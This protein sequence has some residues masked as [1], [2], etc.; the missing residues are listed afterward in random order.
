MASFRPFVT[1]Y[2]AVSD[3]WDDQL[4]V[5]TT[6]FERQI[7]RFLARGYR[8][9]SAAEVVESPHDA[10]LLHV[11]FDDAFASIA[12]TLSL[13]SERGVPSTV[14]VCTDYASDGRPL[15]IP[16]L[17][18]RGNA[19]DLETMRWSA[20]RDAAASG[21]VEIG[22]HGRTHADFTKLGD[23]ELEDELSASRA[24]IETE[25]GR[26]CRFLA[27]PF[28]R[29]DARVRAAAAKAGYDAAF[30][31][32]GITSRLD[33]Y[34]L[35]RVGIWRNEPAFRRRIREHAVV[36]RANE[37]RDPGNRTR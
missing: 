16:E 35:T 17:A 5:R 8:P 4:A 19:E 15:A 14:F 21:L 27:Y 34:R 37:R 13:L 9:A 2:H 28:G 7:D 24:A 18:A 22:S 3:S 1:M 20:L 25:I 31:I 26:P 10:R 12:E 32:H 29:H 33:R 6:D 23:V 30:A 11:T 36:R